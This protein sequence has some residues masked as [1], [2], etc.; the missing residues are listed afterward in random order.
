MMDESEITAAALATAL[1][2]LVNTYPT[3]DE[4]AVA[5]LIIEHDNG[6]RQPARLQ[7]G[8]LDWLLRMIM[9]EVATCRNAHRDGDDTCAHCTGTGQARTR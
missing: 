9:D 8:H 4:P 6:G 1:H 2:S 3:D 7:A 5:S